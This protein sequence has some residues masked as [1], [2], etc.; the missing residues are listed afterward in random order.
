MNED[1]KQFCKS[2]HLKRIQNKIF[3]FILYQYVT[4]NFKHFG[5][6]N[7]SKLIHVKSSY[8][9]LRQTNFL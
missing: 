2:N 7:L 3:I 6:L 4:N 1:L 8:P 5:K 9:S